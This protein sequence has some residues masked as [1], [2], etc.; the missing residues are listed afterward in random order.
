M[1]GVD[2]FRLDLELP[3]SEPIVLIRAPTRSASAE[4]GDLVRTG[5]KSGHH[6][7]STCTYKVFQ[8]TP[9]MRPGAQRLFQS[10]AICP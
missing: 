6:V 8:P 4:A 9:N 7:F 3:P 1:I 2:E 5:R 10:Q